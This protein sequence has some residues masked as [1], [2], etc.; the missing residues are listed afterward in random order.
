MR[1]V[2]SPCAYAIAHFLPF[3]SSRNKGFK[4]H[5]RSNPHHFHTECT[6][7]FALFRRWSL[8]RMLGQYLNGHTPGLSLPS[9]RHLEKSQRPKGDFRGLLGETEKQPRRNYGK[10]E[11]IPD[12]TTGTPFRP[13][14]IYLPYPFRG[15][16]YP[17]GVFG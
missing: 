12:A 4:N 14:T 5:G 13:V 15:T 16:N 11:K 3:D 6:Q 9:A 10:T 8:H 17:R 1:A 7:Q 2:S